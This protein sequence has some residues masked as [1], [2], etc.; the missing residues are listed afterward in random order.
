MFISCWSVSH[1]TQTDASVSLVPSKFLMKVFRKSESNMWNISLSVVISWYQQPK[2][3]NVCTLYVQEALRVKC[4]K[5]PNQAELFNFRTQAGHKTRNFH[6]ASW[7][8]TSCCANLTLA[9]STEFD[10]LILMAFILPAQ[11]FPTENSNQ[12]CISVGTRRRKIICRI[13]ILAFFSIQFE[14]Q[15]HLLIGNRIQE[16]ENDLQTKSTSTRLVFIRI[17]FTTIRPAN[18][19]I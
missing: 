10:T 15:L 18:R 7:D 19:F 14:I 5:W 4:Q 3:K 9:E 6:S 11:Y 1:A 16:Q 13:N 8:F 17:K 12:F 2:Q